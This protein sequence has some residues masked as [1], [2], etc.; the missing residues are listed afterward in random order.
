[1]IRDEPAAPL[2]ADQRRELQETAAVFEMIAASNP[3]DRSVLESL[4]EIYA[5]LGDQEKLAAVQARL[6]QDRKSVV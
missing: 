1:M 3:G 2:T 6:G 4:A 5:R